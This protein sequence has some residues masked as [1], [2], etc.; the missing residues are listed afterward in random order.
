[1]IFKMANIILQCFYFMLPAYFANMA[2]VVAKNMFRKLTL[3]IDFNI[4]LGNSP[5][6]G[7]N[8]TYRG[9][10]A[11]I[12]IA[13]IVAYIQ[14]FLDGNNI[15]AD[16]ALLDYSNWLLIGLLLGFGAIF[17][18]LAKSF[19][20]RR[21]GLKPGMPFLPFDQLDFVFGALIF[22]Y[23]VARLSMEKMAIILFISFILHM[24][25]NHIAFYTSIRK[26]RW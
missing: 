11:G 22:I 26:E 18:D 24:I 15:F 8:K 6:L 17:G 19:V 13:V 1:S 20:K 21:L 10:I 9:L 16:L 2:P 14:F 12:L 3:P 25:I 7:K 23:P 5:I 4:K